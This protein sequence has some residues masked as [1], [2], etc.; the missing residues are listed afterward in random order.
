MLADSSQRGMV[1]PQRASSMASVYM[2]EPAGGSELR[3]GLDDRK[4]LVR[5]TILRL[6]STLFD[7]RVVVTVPQARVHEQSQRMRSAALQFGAGFVALA[8]ALSAWLATIMAK[9][10][11]LLSEAASSIAL[12]NFQA[13]FLL[14]TNIPRELRQLGSALRAMIATLK[15]HAERLEGLVEERTQELRE[16]N[17]ALVNALEL[18][19]DKDRRLQA[20]LEQA[21]LFQETLLPTP[22]TYS[23]LDIAYHF[24]PL[25]QVSGDIFDI[26]R[27]EPDCVRIFMA[28]AIGHGVQAAMRTILLKSTYERLKRLHSKPNALLSA[29]NQ[30]L[31]AQSIGRELQCTASCLDLRPSANGMDV[32]FASAGGPPVHLLSIDRPPEEQFVEGPLLGL[33]NVEVSEFAQFRVMPGQVLLIASDGL[34]EQW[35]STQERF[36]S[37]LGQYRVATNQTAA[38]FLQELILRFDE[39]RDAASIGDDLTV[40]AIRVS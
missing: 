38:E 39:F 31:L 30:A 24:A 33:S 12:G 10:L 1:N 20:D 22:A 36:E 26:C 15:G 4:Q 19:H 8:I 34:I 40:V 9:P 27:R 7:W 37:V 14:P 29:F 28:D 18:L 21:K 25:E 35:N 32:E 2:R 17:D 23:G 3:L 11:H 13:K 5:G 6:P 16:K